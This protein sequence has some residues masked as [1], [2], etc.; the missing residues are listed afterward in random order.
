MTKLQSLIKGYFQHPVEEVPDTAM[1][2]AV[3]RLK[4]S[5]ISHHLLIVNQLHAIQKRGFTENM[6][7]EEGGF[8]SIF[9][10]PNVIFLFFTRVK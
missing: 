9:L 6:S 1:S 7:G 2:I 5:V 10:L 8:R 3:F 4:N